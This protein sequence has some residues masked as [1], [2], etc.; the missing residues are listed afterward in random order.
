M[1]ISI[2][3]Q[4]QHNTIT[5]VMNGVVSRESVSMGLVGAFRKYELSVLSVER[6]KLYVVRPNEIEEAEAKPPTTKN[7]F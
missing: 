2:F 5:R 7:H 3:L 4:D 1:Y 6:R